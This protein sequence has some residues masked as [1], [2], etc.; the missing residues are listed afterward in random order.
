MPTSQLVT[1]GN[2][3]ALVTANIDYCNGI[4][5]GLA[6]KD[7]DRLQRLQNRAA[8]LVSRTLEGC[9]TYNT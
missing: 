3:F 8:R 4:L 2:K 5:G 1:T 7:V 9:N 6:T